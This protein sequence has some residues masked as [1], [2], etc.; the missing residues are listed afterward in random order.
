MLGFMFF[1]VL[2]I[3]FAPIV[4]KEI[5]PFVGFFAFFMFIGIYINSE[6]HINAKVPLKKTKRLVRLAIIF[7]IVLCATVFGLTVLIDY[8]AFLINNEVLSILRFAIICF[9]PLLCPYLLFI[10]YCIIEPFEWI[11]R[12]KY[13]QQGKNVLDKTSAIKIGITGSYGK[14][15]VKEILKTILSQKYRVLATPE[16]YNTTLGVAL[17]TKKLDSTHDVFIAEMGA[18]KKGDIEELAKMIKPSIGIITGIN[19]QHL[20]TFKT[21]ENTMATKYELIENLAENGRAF[22]SSDNDR[23]KEL[24]DK[25]DKEKYTAGFSGGYVT[26][27]DVKTTK[28]GTKFILKIQGEEPQECSTVLL[29]KGALSNICLAAAVASKIGLSAKEIADGI[30]RVSRIGHRLE[31][32]PN[33][34]GIVIIDDSYNGNVDGVNSAMEVL[35]LFEGR[36]I[37]L[38]PGL[39]ELGKAENMANFEFGKTLA[40]H[41]DKVIIIGKHNAE[42]LI[43]GLFEGGMDRN[44]IIFAKNLKK[45]NEELNELVKEDDIVLFENDLP[46]NYN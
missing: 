9:L 10:A 23:T 39:V 8:L 32:V 35:D 30:N 38:T 13:I 18:R 12:N 43:Q 20:E 46:D 6:Q 5:A 22:F 27:E 1:L 36:K 15:T 34:R 42:M 45:G 19:N 40:K 3:C 21:V 29:G 4:G 28:E 11:L 31:L 16:S 2:S 7:S 44:N 24:F 41:A 33:N 17:T 25:C 26:V 37:V 14:T